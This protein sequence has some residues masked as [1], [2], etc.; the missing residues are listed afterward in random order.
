MRAEVREN[1]A[2]DL[3]SVLGREPGHL[4]AHA[5]VAIL[6]RPDSEAL[7]VADRASRE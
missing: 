4:T 2:S 5:A 1:G 6:A 7:F 3:G